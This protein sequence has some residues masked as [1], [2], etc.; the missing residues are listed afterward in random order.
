MGGQNHEEVGM[1]LSGQ[2]SVTASDCSGISAAIARD[3]IP[4]PNSWV[5]G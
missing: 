3:G 5:K 4:V 2:D 1:I